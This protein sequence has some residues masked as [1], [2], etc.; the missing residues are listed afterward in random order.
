MFTE[1][2]YQFASYA[3]NDPL[4]VQVVLCELWG[5]HGGD[6]GD[7]DGDTGKF[8]GLLLQCVLIN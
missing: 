5:I 8:I 6:I 3:K 1:F 2:H 7:R 4:K